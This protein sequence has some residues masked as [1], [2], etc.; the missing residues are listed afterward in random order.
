VGKTERW[1]GEAS[2]W[3]GPLLFLREGL[4]GTIVY[5]NLCWFSLGDDGF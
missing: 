5:I 4:V 3:E 1:L 2:R